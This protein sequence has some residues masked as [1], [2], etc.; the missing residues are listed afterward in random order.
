MDID[1][2]TKECLREYILNRRTYADIAKDYSKE[3]ETVRQKVKRE[4]NISVGI[5]NDVRNNDCLNYN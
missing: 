1:N 3:E 5:I 4:R 2:S